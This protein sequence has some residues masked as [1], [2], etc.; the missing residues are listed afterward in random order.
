MDIKA[1]IDVMIEFL[2]KIVMFAKKSKEKSCATMYTVQ[3]LDN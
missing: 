3:F 1:L 2:K